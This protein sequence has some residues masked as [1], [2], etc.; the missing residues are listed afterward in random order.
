MQCHKACRKHNIQGRSMY[1]V[2]VLC[3]NLNTSTDIITTIQQYTRN[4]HKRHPLGGAGS[5]VQAPPGRFLHP[6]PAFSPLF[7]PLFSTHLPCSAPSTTATATTPPPP[8]PPPLPPL[9][10]PV[11]LP[12]P[13]PAPPTAAGGAPGAGR[14]RAGAAGRRLEVRH[15][16]SMQGGGPHAGAAGAVG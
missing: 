8:P 1:K 10:R 4:Q 2:L 14:A 16:V 13:P 3:H 9:P 6:S 7:S 12:P 5:A 11:P 15:P